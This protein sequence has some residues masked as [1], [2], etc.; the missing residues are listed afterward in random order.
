MT[1]IRAVLA[2][3]ALGILTGCAHPI[4]ITPELQSLD[5]TQVKPIDKKVGYYISQ[6]DRD[7][8]VTTPG[9]GGDKV[10]YYPYK[11]LE[12]ALQKVLNNVFQGIERVQSPNDAAY[13][14]QHGISYVFVP[15]IKTDSSS[16]GMLTWM[17]TKFTVDLTCKAYDDAGAQIWTHQFSGTGEAVFSELK[18][19]FSLAAKRASQ[20][21]FQELQGAVNNAA[22]FH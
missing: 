5:R 4:L 2:T 18:S 10:A 19:D 13:L 12:P 22:E 21:A 8:K 6:A 3:F 1:M 15:T 17:P 16:S 11:E 20:K 7:L 9:G 14:K